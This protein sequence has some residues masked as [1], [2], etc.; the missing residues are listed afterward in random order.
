MK[1]E[2]EREGETIFLIFIYLQ[3]RERRNVADIGYSN[4]VSG[5]PLC[6]RIRQNRIEC[7]VNVLH[8][9]YF[10]FRNNLLPSDNRVLEKRIKSVKTMWDISSKRLFYWYP[11][12]KPTIFETIE[13]YRSSKIDLRSSTILFSFDVPETLY[14]I[15]KKA[16]FRSE[17]IIVTSAKEENRLKVK[18][19]NLCKLP[20]DF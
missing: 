10:L 20:S 17:K 12:R 19:I 16:S 13:I 6:L 15:K 9:I 14:H 11:S 18:G 3:S 8:T 7:L 4:H 5:E 1:K 2:R